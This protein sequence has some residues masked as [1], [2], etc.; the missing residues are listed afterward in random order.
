MS[1]LQSADKLCC[2][3]SVSDPS[4]K[5]APQEFSK[6]LIV[7]VERRIRPY[8]AVAVAVAVVPN[9]QRGR[10]EER[11]YVGALYIFATL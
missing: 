6:L 8:V 4:I 3:A 2:E 9:R 7:A 1:L 10:P 5:R 11:R